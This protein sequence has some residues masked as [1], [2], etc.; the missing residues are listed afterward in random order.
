RPDA[1][2]SG[3]SASAA[4]PSGDA[5]IRLCGPFTPAVR[6]PAIIELNDRS[7]RDRC[8]RTDG[9]GLYHVAQVTKTSCDPN[10][11]PLRF[12][13]KEIIS[14]ILEAL[15][16]FVSRLASR[17][18]ESLCNN[19]GKSGAVIARVR[20]QWTDRCRYPNTHRSMTGTRTAA[21]SCRDLR[22]SHC[23]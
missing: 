12:Y 7:V 23:R 15:T 18:P 21:E 16:G 3:F 9:Y 11:I 8:E 13:D 6:W 10:G 5:S 14:R 4:P 20:T 1:T 19:A 17:S 22:T 2:S